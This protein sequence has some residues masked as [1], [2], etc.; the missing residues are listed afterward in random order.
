MRSSSDMGLLLESR[1][2]NGGEEAALA[3]RLRL[4]RGS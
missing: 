2:G 1:T 4:N 3:I